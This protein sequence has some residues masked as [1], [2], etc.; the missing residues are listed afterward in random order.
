MPTDNKAKKS[1]TRREEVHNLLDNL[2]EQRQSIQIRTVQQ[3]LPHI[4][5][6]S[7]ISQYIN[8]WKEIN[9]EA[10]DFRNRE[11]NASAAL[12]KL[13]NKEVAT[14]VSEQHHHLNESLNAATNDAKISQ[15]ELAQI[16]KSYHLADLEL[17]S[18]KNTIKDL[19]SKIETSNRQH[20]EEITTNLKLHSIEIKKLEEKLSDRTKAAF[21][22][23]K[24]L[25]DQIKSVAKLEVRLETSKDELR[26]YK[27][28]YDEAGKSMKKLESTINTQSNTITQLTEKLNSEANIRKSMEANLARIPVL[29]DQLLAIPKL[30]SANRK[31]L[32]KIKSAEASLEIELH[33]KNEYRAKI[34]ALELLVKEK[35]DELTRVSVD[36]FKGNNDLIDAY[37]ETKNEND[38]LQT[39]ALEL[40]TKIEE[41]SKL[42]I[43]FKPVEGE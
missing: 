15:A 9:Q 38:K 11:F 10:Y 25:K 20:T 29:E 19:E 14:F 18:S 31:L 1:L 34:E 22:L 40:K 13:L 36:Q 16:E 5:S 12:K 26:S 21:E 37:N 8:E 28:R 33:H 24:E 41:Q 2:F 30:E 4:K 7:C 43:K 35:E 23:D 42:L 32:E 6:F 39:Q 17:T 27:K 3:C